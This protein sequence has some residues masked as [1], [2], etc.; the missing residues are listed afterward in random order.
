MYDLDCFLLTVI[1]KRYH[2]LPRGKKK[3]DGERTCLQ[4]KSYDRDVWKKPVLGFKGFSNSKEWAC[5]I[6]RIKQQMKIINS[7]YRFILIS[8]VD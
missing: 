6:K 2:F 5:K 4:L 7:L 8:L 3:F 1:E